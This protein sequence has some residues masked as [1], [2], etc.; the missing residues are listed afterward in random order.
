MAH[1]VKF[2]LGVTFLARPVHSFS[3]QLVN[4]IIS[5]KDSKS[6]SA[7]SSERALLATMGD[8]FSQN[9]VQRWQFRSLDTLE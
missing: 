7:F 4:V 9:F 1:C 8:R 3:K 5:F 2:F 6:T